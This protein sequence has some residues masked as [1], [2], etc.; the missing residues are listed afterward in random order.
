[1]LM[2]DCL[3][4]R[5]EIYGTGETIGKY[6]ETLVYSNLVTEKQKLKTYG[7]RIMSVTIQK[8]T[9]WAVRIHEKVSDGNETEQ[10]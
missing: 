7:D 10:T 4:L 8:F 1:M 6:Y 5:Q 9:K 2:H 3:C